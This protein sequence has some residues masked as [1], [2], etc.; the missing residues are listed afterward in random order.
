M[1]EASTASQF[2]ATREHLDKWV[3]DEDDCTRGR[4]P[5]QAA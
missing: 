1:A 3:A 4:E 2:V 5:A